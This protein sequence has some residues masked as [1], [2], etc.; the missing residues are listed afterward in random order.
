MAQIRDFSTL[1]PFVPFTGRALCDVG[2]RIL[3]NW[4]LGVFSLPLVLHRHTALH[5]CAGQ[6]AAPT[7]RLLCSPDR[8]L[9]NSPQGVATVVGETRVWNNLD[10]GCSSASWLRDI[11]QVTFSS[12]NPRAKHPTWLLRRQS[13]EAQSPVKGLDRLLV[14]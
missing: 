3:G 8:G 14:C 2:L 12:L 4:P 11:G 5:I 1:C 6:A 13:E 7:S 10:V 9:K